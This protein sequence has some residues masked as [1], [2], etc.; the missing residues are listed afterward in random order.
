VLRENALATGA[1]ADRFQTGMRQAFGNP[2]GTAA[3]VRAGQRIIEVR[4]D[5]S[6]AEAAKAAMKV[7]SSKLPTPCN[8]V[9]T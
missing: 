9:R 1:G 5:R 4:T 6:K 7:A 2:I 3:Q 8:I